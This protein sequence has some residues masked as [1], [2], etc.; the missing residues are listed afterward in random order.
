[1]KDFFF[2]AHSILSFFANFHL[3]YNH[4]GKFFIKKEI[5]TFKV[6]ISGQILEN[7]FFLFSHK[8]NMMDDDENNWTLEA[9]IGSKLMS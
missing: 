5:N 8:I 6:F 7:L 3:F 4:C 9:M 2:F 1:M